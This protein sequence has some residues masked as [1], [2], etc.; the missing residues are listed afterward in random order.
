MQ[1]LLSCNVFDENYSLKQ[2][3]NIIWYSTQCNAHFDKN[4][5]S[6]LL[7]PITFLVTWMHKTRV[8]SVSFIQISPIH[9]SQIIVSIQVLIGLTS[10]FSNQLQFLMDA[11]QSNLLEY[12]RLVFTLLQNSVSLRFPGR[13]MLLSYWLNPQNFFQLFQR[14]AV[15]PNSFFQLR[16]QQL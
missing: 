15:R 8:E 3:K 11:H 9:S 4:C 13:T 2:H 12:Y 5:N 16:C 6:V 14:L 7:I 10:H 1:N